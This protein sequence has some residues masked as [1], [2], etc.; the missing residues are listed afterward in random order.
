MGFEIERKWLLDTPIQDEVMQLIKCVTPSL[1]E[2]AYLT[3]DDPCVRIRKVQRCNSAVAKTYMTVKGKGDLCRAEVESPIPAEFYASLMS[4]FVNRKPIEK[5]YYKIP[6]QNKLDPDH[7][8]CFEISHIDGLWWCVE[9]EFPNEELANNFVVPS[10]FGR[11]VTYEDQ[12]K[13]AVYAK[14]RPQYR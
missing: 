3:F 9:I 13:L 12:F 4:Q 1:V 10:W 14:T 6:F 5:V 2:Q 8:Y 7:E 11:D